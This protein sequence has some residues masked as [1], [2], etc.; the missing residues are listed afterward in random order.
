MQSMS[1]LVLNVEHT[2]LEHRNSE[3]QLLW[4]CPLD[5]IV[6]MAEYT[7][8]EG[9]FLDDYFLVFVSIE[10][11]KQYF[12]TASFYSDGREMIVEHL[13]QKWDVRVKLGLSHSTE[14]K[15]RVLWPPEI[16]GNDYFSFR[17]IQSDSRLEKLR[18]FAFGPARE[19]YPSQE[20]C[21]FLDSRCPKQ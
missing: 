3:G 16:A 11:G 5:S 4:Q 18:G 20:V 8:N 21:E 19:Y 10:K 1:Q 7:T 12:A 13:S 15:S 14:W 17:E 2:A 6:L 9:P